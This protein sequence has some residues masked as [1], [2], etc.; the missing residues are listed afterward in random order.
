MMTVAELREA[1]QGMPGDAQAMVRIQG[2]SRPV[3]GVFT[4]T[5]RRLAVDPRAKWH[6]FD[7]DA[8]VETIDIRRLILSDRKFH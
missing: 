5:E 6:E 4:E 1:L 7:P 3:E 2:V 8:E